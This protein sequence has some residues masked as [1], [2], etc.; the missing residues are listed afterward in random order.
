MKLSFLFSLSFLLI[1]IQTNAQENW[2][3]VNSGT[4]D[5][6][7]DVCFI[8]NQF[9]WIIGY[10]GIL[11]RTSNAGNTWNNNTIPY[12]NLK[13]IQFVNQNVGWIVGDNGLIIKTTDAGNN[14]FEQQGGQILYLEDLYFFD[15]QVGLICG[16]GSSTGQGKI[17]RTINGGSQWDEIA[18]SI[19][20]PRLLSIYFLNSN[21]GWT[22]GTNDLLYRT[23]DGG[24]SWDSIAYFGGGWQNYHY[25]VYFI[26][27]LNGNVCGWANFGTGNTSGPIYKTSDGGYSW[28]RVA[29]VGYGRF[30]SFAFHEASNSLYSVG[31]GG[32]PPYYGGK[33]Y[34]S[35]DGG[36]NWNEVSSPT[37]ERLNK[38]TF[39]QNKGWIVGRNGT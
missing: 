16:G 11:L 36:S 23:I 17:L 7:T 34:K 10:S 29:A 21:L 31:S 14:W 13:A 20:S 33:I 3:V 6:L 18:L 25:G 12:E 35:T 2:N 26:D 30:N 4:T 15:D 22:A 32:Y 37:S 39:T 5:N 24:V 1:S 38:I 8:E 27:S 28:T 19:Y 9:G